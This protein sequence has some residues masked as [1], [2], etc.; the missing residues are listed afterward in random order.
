MLSCSDNGNGIYCVV[1]V[2]SLSLFSVHLLPLPFWWV[3]ECNGLKLGKGRGRKE[4][5]KVP[6]SKIR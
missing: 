6:K 1:R 2:P 5:R 3:Y 4:L